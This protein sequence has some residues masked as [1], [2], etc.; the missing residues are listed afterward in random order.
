MNRNLDIR[1]IIKSQ[2]TLKSLIYLLV[3]DKKKRQLLRLQRRAIV[4]EPGDSSEDSEEDFKQYRKWYQE[5][6]DEL[7]GGND[8]EKAA[9]DSEMKR[10]VA[11]LLDRNGLM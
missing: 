1:N 6:K 7:E 2:E 10:L 11:G 8:D 3:P 4:L 9:W 5:W